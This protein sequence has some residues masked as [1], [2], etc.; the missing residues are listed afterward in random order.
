MKKWIMVFLL[1]LL[2][3]FHFSVLLANQ[4]SS[5]ENIPLSSAKGS[6]LF[7][8]S[9]LPKSFWPLALQFLTQSNTNNCSIASS[10]MVL[11]ALKIRPPGEPTVT[12]SNFFSPAV[13]KILP[14][15]SVSRQGS[16]LDQISHAL[17]TWPVHVTIIHANTISLDQ[18]RHTVIQTLRRSDRYMIVNYYRPVLHQQ[19]K[20]HM[21]P[22]AA[23]D[24]RSD[25]VLIMDVTRYRYPPVWVKTSD[26][27]HAMRTMD[28][29]A[30][31]SR[32]FL[33]VQKE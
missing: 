33:V 12:Q 28:A 5:H 32:G 26:L 9:Y 3:P 17:A 6:T 4:S 23:Y 15:Q 8:R 22:I 30:H 14:M 20:G 29:L 7:I 27:W 13:E 31:A 2:L 25:R 11:N 19:G 24:K 16:T 1:T 10:V 18:F 21:S